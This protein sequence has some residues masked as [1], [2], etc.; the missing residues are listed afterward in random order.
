MSLLDADARACRRNETWGSTAARLFI[1]GETK[2]MRCNIHLNSWLKDGHLRPSLDYLDGVELEDVLSQDGIRVRFDYPLAKPV[3]FDCAGPVTV[4]SFISF[5]AKTYE[6][7]YDEERETATIAEGQASPMLA[8]RNR[9]DGRYGIW[10]HVLNDLFLEGADFGDDG[11]WDL[12]IG[13]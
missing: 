8:N 5:V 10:G 7:I 13:S 3:V 2:N 1:R 6:R 9:T 11:I 12:E 4:K